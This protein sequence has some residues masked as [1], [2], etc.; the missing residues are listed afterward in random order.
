MSEFDWRPWLETS[1]WLDEQVERLLAASPEARAMLAAIERGTSTRTADW[2][3]HL[4]LP[5]PPPAELGFERL[6]VPVPSH[7]EA[8]WHRQA[9][10][11]ML[12]VG[13]EPGL[14]LKCESVV[15]LLEAHGLSRPILGRPESVF[16]AAEL[17]PALSAV[18][19]HGFRGFVAQPPLP[20]LEARELWAA[21]PRREGDDEGNLDAADELADAMVDLVGA[22]VAAA[23]AL[24]VERSHWQRRN[25][26]GQ[27]QRARQGRFGL[28]WAN[29]DHHTFRASRRWFGRLVGLWER[30]GFVARERFYAGGE[31]GWGAQVMEQPAAGLVTFN[32]VDLAPE[33]ISGNLARLE[34]APRG[35]LGTIGLWCALHGESILAAGMHHLEA[36]FAFDALTADLAAEGVGMMP[37]FSDLPH[38]KQAF[39]RGE[40]WPV[41][42]T[43]LHALLAAGQITAEQAERFAREGAIGSHLENLQRWGGFKGFNSKSVSRIIAAVD[44]RGNDS[45]R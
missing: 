1:A 42:E 14:A 15:G 7:A 39:T 27:V 40:V 12:L 4:C 35:E 23:L 6:G 13:G 45:E 28:G 44:P 20:L 43:R 21:R 18:E 2:L 33:E 36:Q 10:F 22:D 24:E 16:R 32:D 19:R 31:A 37:P 29:H 11:P 17:F 25:R 3:D 5:A 30:F 34:L 41:D 9:M 26:A 8:W 38:L